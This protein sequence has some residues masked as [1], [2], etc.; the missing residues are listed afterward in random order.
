MRLSPSAFNAHL[1]VMGQSF[2]WRKAF[3]CPCINPN[4]GAPKPNCQHCLGKGRLWS[5]SVAGKAGIIGRDALRDFA[6]FGVWDQGDIM[7]SIPSDSPLYQI[8]QYDRAMSTNRSEPLSINMTRGQ[9]DIMRTPVLS[10]DRAFWLDSANVIQESGAP[11][12]GVDGILVWNT[13]APPV[14]TTYSLTGRRRQE[15]FVYAEM[16]FDRPIHYGLTLPRRVVIRRFDLY[17]K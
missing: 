17:G 10:I 16:P 14:G 9:N 12:V 3:A 5:A 2:G 6:S 4:S 11:T 13:N 7:L 1:N 8:G 15:Y